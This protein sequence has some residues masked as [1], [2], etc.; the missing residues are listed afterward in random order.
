MKNV[1]CFHAKSLWEYY[2]VIDHTTLPSDT[3]SDFRIFQKGANA[4]SSSPRVAGYPNL[5]VVASAKIVE[6]TEDSDVMSD[7][8]R[9]LYPFV[10]C[11][12]AISAQ[13]PSERQPLGV[14]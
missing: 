6:S 4:P 7:H 2:F 13:S 10:C 1:E 8:N 11:N 9:A 12:K 14:G 5:T 3:T